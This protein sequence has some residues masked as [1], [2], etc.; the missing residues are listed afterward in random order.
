MGDG[1]RLNRPAYEKLIAE[2]IAWLEKSAPDTLERKHILVVLRASVDLYYGPDPGDA[3][4]R[5]RGRGTRTIS[6]DYDGD[7]IIPYEMKCSECGGSGRLPT[8]SAAT[9]EPRPSGE[10][11]K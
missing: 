5:C 3:C 7:P 1:I 6:R 10:E 8:G 9:Q 11:A 2:D 4:A